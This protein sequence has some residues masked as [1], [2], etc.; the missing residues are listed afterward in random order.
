MS[1][2]SLTRRQFLS[3]ALL[4]PAFARQAPRGARFISAVPLG[5]PGGLSNPPFGRLLGSG[6]DARLFTDLSLLGGS[7]GIPQ[8]PVRTPPSAIGGSSSASLVTPNERFFVRTASPSP[9]P[10]DDAWSIRI[11][12][13]VEEPREVRLSDL[14]PHIAAGGRYLIEC[15]GNADQRNYGLLCIA[16]WEVVTIDIV[17]VGVMS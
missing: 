4:A 16:F 11:G 2:L 3:A 17:L 14:Q 7:A 1:S 10:A 15:S 9:L 12:G 6:L 13:L 5:N 8:S